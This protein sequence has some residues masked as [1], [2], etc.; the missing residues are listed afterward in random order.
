MKTMNIQLP[1][2]GGFY[3]SLWRNSDTEYWELK[4]MDDNLEYGMHLEHLDEC[5]RTVLNKNGKLMDSH[6]SLWF[7]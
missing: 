7:A 1:S 2:F 3:E 4:E 5:S 6:N